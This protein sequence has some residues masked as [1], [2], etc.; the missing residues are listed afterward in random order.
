MTKPDVLPHLPQVLAC[1]HCEA[2]FEL[3]AATFRCANGH[4]FDIARQG[5]VNLTQPTSHVHTGDTADMVAARAD[6]LANGHFDALTV[7]L[8]GHARNLMTDTAPGWVMDLG[9]GTG[10]YLSAVLQALPGCSGLAL[11]LSKY[12]IRRAA[13]AQPRMGAVV[14]DVWQRLPV[15]SGTAALALSV[16]APRNTS[17]I[18]RILGQDGRLLLAAPTGEH[19]RELVE[20]LGLLSVDPTKSD[21]RNRKMGAAWRSIDASSVRFEMELDHR[22]I[23]ALVAMGPSAHHVTP[24][25]LGV[26]LR[27]LPDTVTV[28]CS[29]TVEVYAPR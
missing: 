4:A 20:P 19:L 1:P 15:R 24:S 2:S 9:A 3:H 8:A 11:D 21:R 16:F 7:A 25:Q 27:D 18:H 29:V 12:A 28:T 23:T 14:C 17:E 22:Q 26:R 13:R 10:H 6:F 5:Y